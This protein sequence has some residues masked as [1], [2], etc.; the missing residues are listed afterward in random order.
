[1][2]EL[3]DPA[4]RQLTRNILLRARWRGDALHHAGLV[5]DAICPYCKD[6]KDTLRHRWRGYP[7]CEHIRDRDPALDPCVRER[8]PPECL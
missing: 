3:S 5:D 8:L 2:Q 1:M 6:A 7:A 4:L